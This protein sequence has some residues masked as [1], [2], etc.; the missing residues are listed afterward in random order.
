MSIKSE[1]TTGVRLLILTRGRRLDGSHTR[2]PV[3]YVTKS[4]IIRAYP[5]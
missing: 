1:L 5:R 4:Q 2:E 3:I